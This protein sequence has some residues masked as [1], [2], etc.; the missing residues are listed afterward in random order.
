MNVVL[1]TNTVISGL[2]WKG[3]P[4]QVLELARAGL[5]TLYSSPKLLV[6]LE[7]VLGREKFAERL[8]KANVDVADLINNYASLVR[9]IRPAKIEAVILDDP[10]DDHV[11]A[12]AQAAKAEI[13]TSGDSHLLS[14]KEYRGILILTANQLI[15]KVG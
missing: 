11:L 15:E 5:I 10:D 1:D 12:C 2:F 8:Q 7:D 9:V 4:R 3:A 14:L 6:E 13:I